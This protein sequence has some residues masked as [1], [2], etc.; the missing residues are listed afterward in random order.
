[1]IIPPP[2]KGAG[3]QYARLPLIFYLGW[4]IKMSFELYRLLTFSVKS[5]FYW[6][7]NRGRTSLW[8]HFWAICA[9]VPLVMIALREALTELAIL[10]LQIFGVY[11]R[12]V[13]KWAILGIFWCFW[14]IFEVFCIP[15]TPSF[16]GSN[17]ATPAKLD[18][19]EH[20]VKRDVC[21][22]FFLQKYPLIMIKLRAAP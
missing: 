10:P 8:G 17:P 20:L 1:M 15:L 18:S 2:T 14:A 7:W 12:S 3:G 11:K 19:V 4:N 22:V 9:F 13:Q 6:G 5:L 21:R 16:V